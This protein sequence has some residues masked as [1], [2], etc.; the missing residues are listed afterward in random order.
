MHQGVNGDPLL[1]LM[2]DGD[3]GFEVI[4]SERSPSAPRSGLFLE[5]AGEGRREDLPLVL[6]TL[7]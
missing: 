6:P 2:C 3:Q 7:S 5:L 1:G 4:E